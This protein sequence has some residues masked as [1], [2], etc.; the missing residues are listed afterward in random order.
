MQISYST[1][2]LVVSPL[3]ARSP[4]VST[5]VTATTTPLAVAVTP[6]S[7]RTPRATGDTVKRSWMGFAELLDYGKKL[8]LWTCLF[9]PMPA[10]ACFIE[11]SGCEI[12]ATEPLG[13][14]L[15]KILLFQA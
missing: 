15:A 13:W 1:A 8:S 10:R 14:V 6:G 9:Q 11:L 12:N 3:P 5:R 4:V 2:R 7:A